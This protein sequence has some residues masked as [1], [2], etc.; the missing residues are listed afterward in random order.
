MKVSKRTAIEFVRVIFNNSLGFEPP[1][2][3]VELGNWTDD[4]GHIEFTVKDGKISR[5]YRYMD[6]PGVGR[7]MQMVSDDADFA[8]LGKV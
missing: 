3:A 8:F 4:L 6:V 5:Q 1:Y 7:R 2:A